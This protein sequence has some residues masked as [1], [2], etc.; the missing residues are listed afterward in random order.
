[1]ND[2]K[3]K[4][5]VNVSHSG[6]AEELFANLRSQLPENC[7]ESVIEAIKGIYE[8]NDNKP[9]GTTTVFTIDTDTNEVNLVYE[10]KQSEKNK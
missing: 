6:S 9:V 10:D 3:E 8:K 4:S 5:S 7:D 1:M 2:L